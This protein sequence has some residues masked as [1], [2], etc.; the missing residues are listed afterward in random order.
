MAA[1]LS[2]PYGVPVS[3]MGSWCPKR[4]PGVRNGVLV[5]EM[6]SFSQVYPSPLPGCYQEKETE[7]CMDWVKLPPLDARN[8]V[9]KTKKKSVERTSAQA[10]KPSNMDSPPLKR[11]AG[12]TL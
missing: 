6:G 4:G 2:S 1:P 12:S 10:S 3:E 9:K 5:S 7:Y 8:M 11:G